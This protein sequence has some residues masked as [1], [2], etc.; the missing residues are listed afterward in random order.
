[1]TTRFILFL[2]G[3][4]LFLSGGF[5]ACSKSKE[6]AGGNSA[7]NTAGNT[8]GTGDQG[9][10]AGAPPDGSGG[11]GLAGGTGGTAGSAAECSFGEVDCEGLV[12]RRCS[13]L[14][15][16]VA[17][18][19]PCAVGCLDGECAMCAEGAAQCKDGAV[20]E[21]TAGSWTTSE[22]CDNACEGATC[23]AA[24]TE[25]RYQCNGDRSLQQCVG[26]QYV[27]DT[28]CDFLCRNDECTGECMPDTRR[29]NP[30]AA[31][32]SQICNAEGK[33][34]QSAPCAGNTFCVAGDCKPCS[35]GTKRCADAGPQLC[36]D[37]GE[38]VNQG[39]CTEPNAVCFDGACV[40]CDPGTKRCS[41]STLEQCLSDGSGWEVLETCSGSTP[42]CLESTKACGKCSEGESQC[43]NDQLQT[44]DDAGAWQTSEVCSNS[45]STPRCFSKQ[46]TQ[47]NPDLNER[48]CQT[49]GSAQGC[50]SNGSWGAA[51]SCTG[52][53]PVCREDLNFVCG[54]EEGLRR[55]RNSTVPEICQG[56]AWVPQ[57]ACA[58]TLDYCLPET[59]RCVDCEPETEQCKSGVAN[60]CTSQGSWQSLN[61]CAGDSIN[62]G[63]CDLG[64]DCGGNSDCTSGACVNGVCRECQP[65]QRECV[66]DTPRLCASNGSWTA[67]AT[68]SGNTPACLPST[69]Q[70]VECL[71][72]SQSC[73]SCGLGTQSCSSN[74]WGSCQGAVN[75]QTSNQH[76]GTCDNA[77]QTR[78]SCQ[79]GSCL[80]SSGNHACGGSTRPCYANSDGSHCGSDCFN[81]AQYNGTTG[82]CSSGQCACQGMTL[83]CASSEPSCGTWDFESGTLERWV[84]GDYWSTWDQPPSAATSYVEVRTIS[85]SKAMAVDVM[86]NDNGLYSV[87]FKIALCPNDAVISTSNLKLSYDV[88]FQTTN[89][90][91]FSSSSN[92]IVA[93]RNPIVGC[94]SSPPSDQWYTDTCTILPAATSSIILIMRTLQTWTGTIFIDNVTISPE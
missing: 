50:N 75:L 2:A 16:W 45:S 74:Q 48:R 93:D 44:C 84:P 5:A 83:D 58:G 87:E 66:G 63:G 71:S 60:V 90:A 68:C 33:W 86:S 25:G 13:E 51:T 22:V 76:C 23:V 29:C 9:G 46:C 14:G 28:E 56:G 61:S 27:D 20:Q 26:G 81:C 19:G 8:G 73:G 59:G 31:N 41:G 70:C 24:C 11:T 62:C 64:D 91:P 30:D 15:Q 72:G 79:S 69:G 7:G 55:C 57:S 89:G 88:Y 34:D 37:A 53:T 67:Q 82:A 35:P 92:F 85:G 38:W 3:F 80:C 54:C 47:C 1:M 77:C 78:E 40:P 10:Q 32:E 43:N 52:D 21:C 49:N 6:F 18:Q 65:G 42:A 12:P 4:G 17:T 94:P 36:S 39:A